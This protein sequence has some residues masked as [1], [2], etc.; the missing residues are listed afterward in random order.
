MS[1]PPVG[2]S[3]RRCRIFKVVCT[4]NLHFA[5]PAYCC[6]FTRCLLNCDISLLLCSDYACI[7]FVYGCVIV[8]KERL[9]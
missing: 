4:K 1:P 2:F 7:H 9:Q 5:N 6:I 8:L 3:T